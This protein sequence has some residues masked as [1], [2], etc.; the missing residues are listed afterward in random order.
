MLLGCRSLLVSG[1]AVEFA[2]VDIK[3]ETYVYLWTHFRIP[4]RIPLSD[5]PLVFALKKLI[6]AVGTLRLKTHGQYSRDL[7]R[8]ILWGFDLHPDIGSELLDLFTAMD[9]FGALHSKELQDKF[10]RLQFRL[11]QHGEDLNLV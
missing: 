10:S 8:C 7:R 6:R 2:P 9:Q 5:R 11:E 1:P 4:K 3:Q